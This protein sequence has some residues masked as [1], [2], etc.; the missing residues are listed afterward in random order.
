MELKI[1][2]IGKFKDLK[3]F[4]DVGDLRYS[5]TL[6]AEK[7]SKEVGLDLLKAAMDLIEG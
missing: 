7:E 5:T 4:D 3:I 1:E 6:M 2:Y